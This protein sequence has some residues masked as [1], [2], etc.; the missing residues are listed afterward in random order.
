M[1][2]YVVINVIKHVIFV[3]KKIMNV[4][5]N[6]VEKGNTAR[7]TGTPI[8]RQIVRDVSLFSKLY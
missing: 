6:G 4:T 7:L 5:T 2:E 3:K 1:V 8:R